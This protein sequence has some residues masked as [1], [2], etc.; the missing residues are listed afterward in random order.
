MDNSITFTHNRIKDIYTITTG[1][2]G[3]GG[4]FNKVIIDT[5]GERAHDTIFNYSSSNKI[6]FYTF[7]TLE[8]FEILEYV[9][10]EYD[11]STRGVNI[12][13]LQNILHHI[14]T[15]IWVENKSKFRIN[16][17]HIK[18]NMKYEL[19]P[20]QK[21]AMENYSISK[22][23]NGHRGALMYMA[24]G[25]G[26]ALQ[27]DT[28][29]LTP[30]G[31]VSIGSLSVGDEVM[32]ENNLPTEVTGVYP[33]GTREL[34]KLIFID[35][36]SVIA[37]R[38]HLW[39]I[40]GRTQPVTTN[41]MIEAMDNSEMFRDGIRI[42]LFTP[43]QNEQDKPVP[44]NPYLLGAILGNDH[45]IV[46]LLRRNLED[47]DL[48][49][50][51]GS[52]NVTL[53]DDIAIFNV[54]TYNTVNSPISTKLDQLK[55]QISNYSKSGNLFI[56]KRYLVGTSYN[57]K[58]QLLQG[59]M[60][61]YGTVNEQGMVIYKTAYIS[62]AEDIIKLVHSL[63]GIAYIINTTKRNIRRRRRGIGD[64]VYHLVSIKLARPD[65]CFSKYTENKFKQ[66]DMNKA[67]MLSKDLTTVGL[68]LISIEQV[69]DAEAVCISVTNPT[70]LFVVDNYCVTH[71]TFTS[72]ATHEIMN[73]I[74]TK[75]II[76]APNQT[77]D[78]VWVHALKDEI[79]KKP[80]DVYVMNRDEVMKGARFVVSSFESL[81]LLLNFV[82]V[83]D[84]SNA[85]VIVDES[86]NFA[87][88][89]S[90]RTQLLV[91]VINFINAKDVILLSG[92]PIKAYSKETA[93]LMNLLDTRYDKNIAKRF[94]N[95]YKTPKNL[96]RRT[97]PKRFGDYSVIVKK[98]VIDLEPVVTRYFDVHLKDGGDRFTLK[99]IKIRLQE[100]VKRREKEINEAFQD[101]VDT[102]DRLYQLAKSLAKAN[103]MSDNEF[104]VYE[105]TFKV[106]KKAY[107]LKQ[108]PFHTQEVMDVNK[109]EREVLLP[110]LHG[111]DKKAFREAK[112]VVKYLLLKVQGEALAHVVTRARIECHQAIAE[113]I[114]WVDIVN[115]TT[116]KTIVF[117]SYID[118]CESA[119]SKIQTDGYEPLQV[120]GSTS[121]NLSTTVDK[122]NNVKSA[123]PLIA[124][125]A[126]LS[127]GVPLIAANIVVFI[128]MPFRMATYQQAIARAHRLGQDKQVIA[129]IP[130]LRTG[131]EP[132]INGRNIDIIHFFKEAVERITGSES[133]V[134]LQPNVEP[135]Y[136]KIFES[137][138]DIGDIFRQDNYIVNKAKDLAETLL[139][140]W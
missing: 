97:L 27:Y 54:N 91:E 123:N 95:I 112:S 122:F 35:G 84:F 43:N 16:N 23:R 111:E 90:N 103:G 133:E 119:N 24:T 12:V 89:R 19:L 115:S 106:V 81:K 29:V 36:R 56:P 77:I 102:Y 94:M 132:N 113:T 2:N 9:V 124:T 64:K 109:F 60:E 11:G 5:I 105:D 107:E 128:D 87:N 125:Y 134:D 71:N 1:K 38:E 47:E 139:K 52:N 100:F 96:L 116:K 120:Y 55:I 10:N 73:N 46:R 31:W 15:N 32:C 39:K 121:H 140:E 37:D 114:S 33:Q 13:A 25:T 49:T 65:I 7:F 86:H 50:V 67:I 61:R 104:I 14:D 17:S 75:A 85:T 57:Q 78:K 4:S 51:L 58:V 108:L 66:A 88:D 136:Q 135:V 30:N 8:V 117:S 3:F 79:Y 45:N 22:Q 41:D 74:D 130:E 99:N 20:H 28:P 26:K 53:S 40:C 72:L 42:P 6:E 131:E 59:L 129:Y 69:D 92:T 101:Y 82:K 98:D 118:V 76:I 138:Y 62:L 137:E 70:K 44:I 18:N 48:L 21:T 68:R 127:T 80:Q 63:G 83:H 93:V 126:S 34:F 110:Q